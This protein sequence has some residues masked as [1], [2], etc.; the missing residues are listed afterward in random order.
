MFISIGI[1]II[2]LVIF[3]VYFKTKIENVSRSSDVLEVI[4][5]EVNQI[6]IE[7]NQTTERNIVLIEEKINNLNDLLKKSDKIISIIKKEDSKRKIVSNSYSDIGKNKRILK[8]RTINQEILYLHEQGI[9][10][11][12]ISEKTGKPSGEVE[13]VI[14][15]NSKKKV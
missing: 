9:D 8:K 6:I 7:L 14:S 1:N 12:I 4:A 10:T 13:L 15:L 3:F 2:I 11:R 5:E